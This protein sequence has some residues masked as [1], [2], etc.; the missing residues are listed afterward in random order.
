MPSR[1][2]VFGVNN[3]KQITEMISIQDLFWHFVWKR[4]SGRPDKQTDRRGLM[5]SKLNYCWVYFNNQVAFFRIFLIRITIN[6]SFRCRESTSDQSPNKK[7]VQINKNWN[8]SQFLRHGMAIV[9]HKVLASRKKNQICV[10]KTTPAHPRNM[11][12]QEIGN[13]FS[14]EKQIFFFWKR[15]YKK[16]MRRWVQW[17][18][19]NL[20][21]K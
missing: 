14:K 3:N 15:I 16:K 10:A 7:K 9:T 20:H 8:H 19:S 6:K 13:I 1:K 4:S 5:S 18:G 17:S 11:Y 2:I 12:A 21:N